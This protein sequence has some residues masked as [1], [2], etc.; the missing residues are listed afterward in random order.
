MITIPHN[1]SPRPYQVKLFNAVADGCKRA[2]GVWHRRAG[3]DK[4]LVNLVAKEAIKTKGI[5]YYFFPT[6]AQ[7]RKVLWDGMDRDGF[8]FMDHLPEAIRARTNTSEMKVE[9]VNGSI[10]QVI[11]TDNYDSI[12]GTNPRGCVFSEYALQDPK[13]WQ[14]I[15]PILAENQGWAAFNF[16][17]RGRNHGHELYAMAKENPSWFCELLTV[18]DSCSA[19]GARIIDDAMIEAERQAGMDEDLIQQEFYCSWD[20]AV[21]GA[22]YARQ[23]AAARADGRI[24]PVP[25]EDHLPVHTAWDLGIGDATAIWLL[26]IVGREIHL[27]DYYETSGEGLAHYAHELRRR[28]H[29]YGTHLGPH[30]IEVRE[31]G[32]GK[33]R[34]EIS[35]GLGLTFTTVKQLPIDDGIA[36]ARALFSRCWFDQTRCAHG[37]D[38]LAS[39][40]KDYDDKNQ[41]FKL[42]PVHDWASHGADAFRTLAVGIDL[43][44]DP[45]VYRYEMAAREDYI[46]RRDVDGI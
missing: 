1:F 44:A 17:P 10:V 8:R 33:S 42:R 18:E 25:I 6:F 31:L 41:V 12:M 46:A 21:P 40:H 16:T 32:T 37:L 9:L 38:A 39:Y 23:L 15:R 4:V 36:A 3:K 5:Y 28:G 2:V 22:Y 14:Y 45:G 11:G 34:K 19:S 24:C 26:Q 30:D 35:A 27:V 13:A 43:I 7:G 20:A 29:L